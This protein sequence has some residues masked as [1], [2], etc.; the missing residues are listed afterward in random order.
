MYTPV[1]LNC[2]VLRVPKNMHVLNSNIFIK[3]NKTPVHLKNADS[4]KVT[5]PVSA[6]RFALV[7]ETKMAVETTTADLVQ[8]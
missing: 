1:L 6:V 4:K 3:K 5:E 2:V 7:S 8:K